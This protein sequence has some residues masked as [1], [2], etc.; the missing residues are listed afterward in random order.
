MVLSRRSL[1]TGFAS[2]LAAPA[3]VR[4]SS[5][6]PVKAPIS[7]DEIIEA[8]WL[9]PSGA[10]LQYRRELIEALEAMEFTRGRV[11]HVVTI[12]AWMLAQS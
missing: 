8:F 11:R 2:L 6:M 12:P 1:I 3:I 5:L 10:A 4:A 7:G 9:N